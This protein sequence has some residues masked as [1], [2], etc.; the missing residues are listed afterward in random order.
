MKRALPALLLLAF[1]SPVFGQGAVS[2]VNPFFQKFTPGTGKVELDSTSRIIFVQKGGATANAE[3]TDLLGRLQSRRGWLSKLRYATGLELQVVAGADASAA[4]AKDIVLMPNSVDG[5]ST[6]TGLFTSG[7]S[8]TVH[9]D[10]SSITTSCTQV[11]DACQEVEKNIG[12]NVSKEGYQ[13]QAGTGGV[14]LR[15][16]GRQGAIWGVTSL[17]RLLMQDGEDAGEHR[18]LPVGS[19]IDYPKHE[20]RRGMIDVGRFFVPKEQIIGWLEKM[21]LHKMNV[22]QMHVNDDAPP[23]GSLQGN[24]RGYFRLDVNDAALQKKMTPDGLYY[25]KED[26]A[27]MEAAAKRYGIRIVPE[28]AALA[29]SSAFVQA[30]DSDQ[31]VL[32]HKR[33]HNAKINYSQF[34]TSTSG[35]RTKIVNFVAPMITVYRDWFETSEG[36]VQLGFDE[37]GGNAAG[38]ARHAAYGVELYKAIVGTG[39]GKYSKTGYWV[40]RADWLQPEFQDFSKLYAGIT[41]PNILLILWAN[42]VKTSIEDIKDYEWIWSNS[43]IGNYHVPGRPWSFGPSQG[44]G[45]PLSKAFRYYERAMTRF[46]AGGTLPSGHMFATWGD[47]MNAMTMPEEHYNLGTK[48]MISSFGAINWHGFF[49]DEDGGRVN[50][51]DAGYES[52]IPVS[53]ELSSYWVRERFPYLDGEH[54]LSVLLQSARFLTRDIGEDSGA[55]LAARWEPLREKGTAPEKDWLGWDLKD[56]AASFRG[57][58]ELAAGTMFV[59]DLPGEGKMTGDGRVCKDALVA[60]GERTVSACGEDE[61]SNDI[62]GAGGIIKKGVGKLMLSGAN[63]FAGGAVIEAGMISVT[64]A[65]NLGARVAFAGGT[66]AFDG[67]TFE[68]PFAV[69]AMPGGG[70]IDGGLSL[71]AGGNIYLGAGSMLT[72]KGAFTQAASSTLNVDVG[73][74]DNGRLVAEGNISV[75][76]VISVSSP[77]TGLTSEGTVGG[78]LTKYKIMEGAARTG[79]YQTVVE[80]LRFASVMASYDA[81]GVFLNFVPASDPPEETDTDTEMEDTDTEM[82]DTDTDTEDTN[83]SPPPPPPTV[84]IV[85]PQPATATVTPL[86]QSFAASDNLII[87]GA[88]ARIVIENKNDALQSIL[89]APRGIVSRLRHAT[90]LPLPVVNGEAAAEGDIILSDA[91][92]ATFTAL[93]DSTSGVSLEFTGGSATRKIGDNVEAEGYQYEVG[94]QGVTVSF[95]QDQGALRGLQTLLRELMRDGS[96]VGRHRWLEIGTGHDYPKYG[97]RTGVL[98]A[99]RL[100]MPVDQ[101]IGWMEKM[102]LYKMNRLHILLNDDATNMG[103]SVAKGYFRLDVGD[104][105]RQATITPDGLFYT[106]EDWDRMEQAAKRYGIVLVPTFNA[107]SHSLAW[108]QDD[109]SLPKRALQ[110]NKANRGVLDISSASNRSS[111]VTYLSTLINSYKDWFQ[112]DKVSLGGRD[113]TVASNSW[114]DY[115]T[116][117][118][119]LHDS[120]KKTNTNTTGFSEVYVWHDLNYGSAVPLNDD[121]TIVSF[122]TGGRTNSNID[123]YYANNDFVQLSYRAIFGPKLSGSQRTGLNPVNGWYTWDYLQRVNEWKNEKIPAGLSFLVENSIARES[124]LD[125]DFANPGLAKSIAAMGIV[126]WYGVHYGVAGGSSVL[127][128]G[129]SGFNAHKDVARELTSFWVRDRFPYLD[130]KQANKVWADTARHRVIRAGSTAPADTLATNARGDW[131]GWD[132]SDMNKAF[133]GPVEF[134]AAMVVDLPGQGG[135]TESGLICMDLHLAER[136]DGVSACE[137][138]TWSNDI[139]G[140]G[141][142]HKKGSGQLILTGD[143]TFTGGALIEGGTVMIS[144]ESNLGAVAGGVTLD[145]G[146]LEFGSGFESMREIN[147]DAGGGAINV[148]SSQVTV[149]GVISGSGNLHKRGVGD[150]FL[151][152]TNTYTGDTVVEEGILEGSVDSIKGDLL[153]RSSSSEAVFTQA[154]AASFAGDVSG[155]GIFL[156]KGAGVLDLTGAAA[157]TE[158]NILEGGI[159][160]SG[161]AFSGDVVLAAS[162]TAEFSPSADLQTPVNVSGSGMIVKTGSSRLNLGGDFSGYTGMMEVRAGAVNVA[163]GGGF[164]GIDVKAQATIRSEGGRVTV[165]GDLALASD[166]VYQLHLG[167][168][169]EVGMT[170]GGTANLDGELHIS[171]D[172][173]QVGGGGLLTLYTIL[174]AGTRQGA[175]SGVVDSLEFSDPKI[176]YLTNSVQVSFERTFSDYV[177][178]SDTENSAAFAEALEDFEQDREGEESIQKIMMMFP[179]DMDA[180]DALASLPGE[181]HSSVQPAAVAFGGSAHRAVTESV[182]VAFDAPGSGTVGQRSGISPLSARWSMFDA[183]DS[184]VLWTKGMKSY[185]VNRGVGD[186]RDMEY[187]GNGVLMGGDLGLAND[188]RL[189]GYWGAG[190]MEFKQTPAGTTRPAGEAKSYHLGGYGGRKWRELSLRGGLSYTKYDIEASR[191][192]LVPGNPVMSSDYAAQALIV[193]GEVGRPYE[194]NGVFFEPFVNFTYSYHATEAF[195]EKDASGAITLRT[196]KKNIGSSSLDLGVSTSN[197]FSLANMKVKAQGMIAWSNTVKVPEVLSSHLIGR[198][199][200]PVQGTETS[201]DRISLEMGFDF[202]VSERSYLSLSYVDSEL[203][204]MSHDNDHRSFAARF[205]YQY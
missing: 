200:V 205:V 41:D 101:V 40:Q 115:T 20:D 175:F 121:L 86:L 114:S 150:L 72:I 111:A 155:S 73:A 169:A 107:P 137:R 88:A 202:E 187:E 127:N 186:V 7:A 156:K 82:E 167:T 91:P 122:S 188:W 27:E 196:D 92:D 96:E 147:I 133:D 178:F 132:V 52:L 17:A 32:P 29:H 59:A 100:F 110:S 197:E 56:M 165:S 189:G 16:Q 152:G 90:G 159:K 79:R 177:E 126:N 120:I 141:S 71:L 8:L 105:T 46:S 163:G 3:D 166:S 81:T 28:F 1:A 33:G 48:T 134:D 39:P 183:V 185:G 119:A 198:H 182:R 153:L 180:T 68:T 34:D 151:E 5:D 171:S 89:V 145:G 199:S 36:E 77:L 66:L 11:V 146:V 140:S 142:L 54:A 45:L 38:W 102:S 93:T 124:G 6:F 161:S 129:A 113:A 116:F 12:G 174:S 109:S 76:G 35:K 30:A 193:F 190:S 154:A 9:N 25:T 47:M 148:G 60:A 98:D 84:L 162:T 157:A 4:T 19:G 131:L 49:L 203:I 78:I 24:G 99:A 58:S 144:Q 135:V 43:E 44:L 179:S 69:E 10:I 42:T 51:V 158:W 117:V 31:N 83:V 204:G 125:G 2:T 194:W 181:V 118:N 53:Q 170:V 184:P 103:E 164:G 95:A 37:A 138:D 18:Y 106:R 22:M 14:T 75:D 112:G 62:S 61:W 176:D 64:V 21:S 70:I 50:Y 13:Y 97:Q 149:G 123:T 128:W 57:P 108:I 23:V 26:W 192:L 130:A 191:V 94:E 65:G 168:S 104:S 15:Y 173:N 172:L 85:E 136:T 74:M 160:V 143:N 201:E 67:S 195:V 80:K 87:I 55:G 63:T 139:S